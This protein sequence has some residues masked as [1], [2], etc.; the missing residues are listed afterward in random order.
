MRTN[1]PL[2]ILKNMTTPDIA[3]YLARQ[4]AF[5]L[6]QVT[7][8]KAAG[9][10]LDQIDARPVCLVADFSKRSDV[11][12]GASLVKM[13]RKVIEALRDM[14][15][16]EPLSLKVLPGAWWVAQVDASID[17]PNVEPG[18]AITQV[19]ATSEVLASHY[20]A[21][22][23]EVMDGPVSSRDEIGIGS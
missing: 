19:I 15:L 17:N 20:R 9:I 18:C 7:L 4:K 5:Q 16:S 14:G 13:S 2:T 1:V 8:S 22:F 10:S 6:A 11:P 21:G 23:C 3:K 12:T